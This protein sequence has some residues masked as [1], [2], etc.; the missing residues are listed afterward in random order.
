MVDV[1]ADSFYQAAQEPTRNE[2]VS[3]GAS[4][5]KVS[6]ARNNMNPRKAIVIRNN[7][8]NQADIITVSFSPVD[9]VANTGIVLKQYESI[10]DSNDGGYKCYQGVIRAVCATANG[11]LLVYER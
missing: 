9:V 7:S 5:V 2:S 6:D 11:V 10:T 4:S 8:P 3:V 1:Y